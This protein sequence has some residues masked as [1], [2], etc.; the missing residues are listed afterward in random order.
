M[1][2]LEK[3]VKALKAKVLKPLNKLGSGCTEVEESSGIFVVNERVTSWSKAV[4][5]EDFAYG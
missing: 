3:Q 4:P 2:K 5:Q 1:K